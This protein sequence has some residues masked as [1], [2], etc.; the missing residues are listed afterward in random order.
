MATLISTL[1]P[2]V[3]RST[4]A[5]AFV[6]NTAARVYFSI[7][8]FN[9]VGDIKRVHY[10]VVNQ[11]TN[12]NVLN[13]DTGLMIADGLNYD[14]NV[15]FYYIDI[16]ADSILKTSA[17]DGK[18]T[19][20]N[21][22]MIYAAQ[23]RF[24]NS[25]DS[26]AN[27]NEYFSTHLANFSEWSSVV[28]LR[29]IIQPV[30]AVRPWDMGDQTEDPN[31][32]P[33]IVPITGSVVF[34]DADLPQ[35]ETETVQYFQIQVTQRDKND[36]LLDSG[37][38]YTANSLDRNQLNYLLDVNQLDIE[39]I[40]S[41]DLYIK[42]VTKNQYSKTNKYKFTISEFVENTD[43]NPAITVEMD[44]ENA[45]ATINI[46]N[47]TSVIGTLY[48]KRSSSLSNF[49][50]WE[51]IRAVKVNSALDLSI[52]DNTVGSGVWYQYYAQLEGA[53]VDTTHQG[54]MSKMYKSSKIFPEFYDAVISRQDKQIS[55]R[56]NY[57]VSSFKPTVNR[58]KVD[59]LGG[60]YPKFAENAILNY[61]QFAIQG[62]ISTQEDTEE[63][64][65]GKQE[66]YGDNYNNFLVHEDKFYR[67]E[68]IKEN[69]NFL[70]EREFR[71]ELTKWLNDGEPKLYRSMTEG[72][73]VI[74]M[75][76][77]TLT[78]NATL[79][80][81]LYTFSATCYEIADGDSLDTLNSLGIYNII[82]PT[83]TINGENPEPVPDYVNVSKPGQLYRMTSA[84]LLKGDIV[85]K[86]ITSDY[87]T[88][89]SGVLSTKYVQNVRLRNVKIWFHS[90][91][92]VFYV[93]AD[94]Q[95]ELIDRDNGTR[96]W[97]QTDTNRY[98]NKQL[99]LGY[100]FDIN[101]L[102]Q[103]K[104]ANTNGTSTPVASDE[105]K[106]DLLPE[107]SLKSVFVNERGFYQIP[108][109]IE[110]NDIEFPQTDDEVTVEYVV[111]YEEHGQ[112]KGQVTST[113]IQRI[114][115]GQ[116]RDIFRPGVFQ[117][118]RILRRYY[119]ITRTENQS[120]FQKM[121]WWKGYCF[122]VQPYSLLRIQE[123][124]KTEYQ[125]IEIGGTGVFHILQDMDIDDFCFLGRRM[126]R[127]D[128]SRLNFCDEWEYV[129][130]ASVV[131]D[132]AVD[133]TWHT[134]EDV[135]TKELVE[136]YD[137]DSKYAGITDSFKTIPQELSEKDQ[138]TSDTTKLAAIEDPKIHMVYQVNGNNYLYYIDNQFYAI[139]L[140]NDLS[141][142]LAK[143][144]V[145]GNFDFYGMVYRNTT[146]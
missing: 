105:T 71:E 75:T 42:F 127:V 124:G 56:F 107:V 18:S 15:G 48:I 8:S 109:D 11:K 52:E 44:N 129:L 23:L 92:H 83:S 6:V 137:N 1:Y 50:N 87:N 85:G 84:D 54:P 4:F 55:L 82:T 94:G 103:S 61:K 29:P 120:F 34:E 64:F 123:H 36:V 60:Q 58:Q 49:K 132:N 98:Q 17:G 140:D 145:T 74:M 47:E 35:K 33:G 57:S 22:N 139:D 38:L 53:S 99:L 73:M 91:P 7:S 68:Y 136:V 86:K 69:Y 12:E 141:A 95:L 46:K 90:R 32:N 65:L 101:S 114:V 5:A 27:T 63:K 143:V 51:T 76:D 113:T 30:L 142:G 59:T 25:T 16:S 108:K 43:F 3:P 135:D 133:E 2:P 93:A 146:L 45:I 80:R 40:T 117:D 138:Q 28:L 9:S 81:R 31:F 106:A 21:Y 19:G 24:D 70:W 77:I 115:V 78:P 111:D 89:Y 100:R 10:S 14:E 125:D 41:Y 118:Q 96:P 110:V 134:V 97:T 39:N 128:E 131:A 20:W 79:G 112:T 144:P 130:D 102:R 116:Q 119:Y 67:D 122:D 13:S 88:R 26:W 72:L 104:D 62:L 37:K 66:F 126:K 121:E